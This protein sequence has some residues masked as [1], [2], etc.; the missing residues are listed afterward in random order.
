MVGMILLLREFMQRIGVPATVFFFVEILPLLTLKL[1]DF[2]SSD[3]FFVDCSGSL[4]TLQIS[5]IDEWCWIF[6]LDLPSQCCPHPS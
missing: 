3:R 2:F 4:N 6:K 1:C 5:L